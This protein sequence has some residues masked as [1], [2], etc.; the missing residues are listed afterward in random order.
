M[1]KVLL[2]LGTRPE[3]IKL[4]PLALHLKATPGISLRLLSTGQHR[5]MLAQVLGFFGLEPDA[6]LKLM[7]PGQTPADIL[8]ASL[9]GVREEIHRERPDW[10]IAQGDTTTATAS[11]LAAFYER[12]PFAHVEAGLRTYDLN[13]PWPEEF[14]RRVLS[15]CGSLHLAPTEEA[16]AALRKEGVPENQIHL[17]G[18][19]GIDA[20]LLAKDI[21]RK[22]PPREITDRWGG[23]AGERFVLCTL[24]R[25]ENFGEPL[26]QV[27]RAIRQLI[28][29]T[30][31]RFVFPVHRNPAVR[32]A[33]SEIFPGHPWNDIEGARL[34]LVDPLEYSEFIYLMDRAHFLLTDSGGVQEEG[35]CFGKPVLVC[36]ES[37]E[38]P[39]AV[40]AGAAICVGTDESA[41]VRE[42]SRLLAD[43]AHYDRMAQ[44]RF[45][46]GDG[47]ASARI[48]ELLLRN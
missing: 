31:M 46:F 1:K 29:A 47:R 21:L 33:V 14:N 24:H 8:E 22:S 36:R 9:K 32:E 37:T 20:L 35:P 26:R 39:E 19:T 18:N 17:T 12:V 13:S 4:A 7:K 43:Q 45:L 15:L 28:G 34:V 5:E 11:G 44:P 23:L 40:A 38:R 3:A 10:V 6:D 2:I 16:A 42:V 48:A 27:L 30:G 25:R 41:V